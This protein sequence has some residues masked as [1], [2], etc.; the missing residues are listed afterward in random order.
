[1][2][3]YYNAKFDKDIIDITPGE[4]L[5]TGE[6]V[7]IST[8]LGSCVAVSLFDRVR[9]MGGM[10]HFMLVES[11]GRQD[12]GDMMRFE[13][14]G[15]YAMQALLNEFLRTGSRKENIQ[16]KVFGGS[17]ILNTTAPRV[18]DIGEQ[19]VQYALKFLENEE[20]PLLAKDTGG[21]RPRRIYLFPRSFK[22]LMKREKGRVTKLEFE[23]RMPR[24]PE[25]PIVL[26]D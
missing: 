19:N 4:F 1:M 2:Y 6:D 25:S 5:A 16:A 8:V 24:R 11:R 18:T 23:E 12:S 13:R 21:D 26:F 10:N 22:I 3:K 20:I 15:S 14:Y 9:L 17:R 7:V